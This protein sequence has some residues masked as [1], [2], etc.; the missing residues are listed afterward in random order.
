MSD[1][2]SKIKELEK[3]QKK[4]DFLKQVIDFPT[5]LKAADED[6]KEVLPE[7]CKLI[8]ELLNP[9]IES[10]ET[11][12]VAI[13]NERETSSANSLFSDN[14]VT[15]L[16]ALINRASNPS[17]LKKPT[18]EDL[19]VPIVPKKP[20]VSTWAVDNQDLGGKRVKTMILSSE[21]EGEVISLNEPFAVIKLD[22]GKIH[23]ATLDKI[24]VL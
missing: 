16:K 15:I 6:D 1:I 23:Q 11:G 4:V 21:V 22:D 17:K 20:K 14:D 12:T 9:V 2:K 24:K 7:V 3:L 10:L 5:K 18:I 13:I 8:E 19:Q